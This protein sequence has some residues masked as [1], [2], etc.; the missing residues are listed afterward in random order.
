MS[1]ANLAERLQPAVVNISTRQSIQVQQRRLPPGFEE[2][3]QRFGQQAP[4]QPQGEGGGTVRQRGG[5]LGSGFI[6]SADGYIVTN[7]HVV[8]PAR[9]DA[10]VEQITV[11]LVRSHRI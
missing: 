11:T 7:N 10:V 1:F 5:S 8:A 9:P 3:F 6:I 2:F 4:Q